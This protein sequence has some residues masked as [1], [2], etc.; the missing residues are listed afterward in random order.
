MLLNVVTSRLAAPSSGHGQ[1]R[2]PGHLHVIPGGLKPPA[3]FPGGERSP[4]VKG[5]GVEAG[6]WLAG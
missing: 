2:Y 5:H 3:G 6:D 1:S 4:G